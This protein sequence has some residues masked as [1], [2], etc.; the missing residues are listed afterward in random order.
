MYRFRFMHVPFVLSHLGQTAHMIYA[1]HLI[2]QGFVVDFHH[3]RI[4]REIDC[5]HLYTENVQSCTFLEIRD[6][7]ILLLGSNKADIIIQHQLAGH[8]LHVT[9]ALAH[10]YRYDKQQVGGQQLHI[11][12][13]CSQTIDSTDC[14]DKEKV[15]HLADGHRLGTIADDAKDSKQT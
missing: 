6:E 2:G 12:D 4:F 8:M 7:F 1:I 13:T 10:P 14:N 9:V 15:S 5:T 3:C 11:A